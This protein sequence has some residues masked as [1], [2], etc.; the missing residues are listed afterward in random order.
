MVLADAPKFRKMHN[1]SS[2]LTDLGSG[3]ID[4]ENALSLPPRRFAVGAWQMIGGECV[5]TLHAG[6]PV[7]LVPGPQDAQRRGAIIVT[8]DL[9]TIMHLAWR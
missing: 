2:F 3:V 5:A 7:V 6:L 4:G 9:P 1:F 8:T